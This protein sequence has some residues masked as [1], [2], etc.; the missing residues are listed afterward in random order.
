MKSKILLFLALVLGGLT[1]SARGAD[2]LKIIISIP[3]M[4]E[5]PDRWTADHK[6]VWMRTVNCSYPYP[7]CSS[8]PLLFFGSTGE[9]GLLGKL[10][11]QVTGSDGKTTVVKPRFPAAS[12]NILLVQKLDAGQAIVLEFHPGPYA[13]PFPE[14][15]NAESVTMRAVFEQE[16]L[17]F[18]AGKAESWRDDAW[19]GKAISDPCEVLF[20]R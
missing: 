14:Q 5:A 4:H 6:P 12:A 13:F 11:F 16:P 9:D 3:Q 1:G 8:R 18:V 15:G 17:S 2:G 10:S 19:I 7:D 20:K